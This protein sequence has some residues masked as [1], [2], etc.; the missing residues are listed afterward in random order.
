MVEDQLSPAGI[1]SPDNA[2]QLL[3]TA[4]L[5]LMSV[6]Q[7][8]WLSVGLTRR[9]DG[10]LERIERLRC[11]RGYGCAFANLNGVV[12]VLTMALTSARDLAAELEFSQPEENLERLPD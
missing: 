10:T 4:C 6:P 7:W 9:T 3:G 5:H 1:L 11:R 8:T 12:S 2:P